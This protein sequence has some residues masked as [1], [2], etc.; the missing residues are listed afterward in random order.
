MEDRKLFANNLR[1]NSSAPGSLY[2]SYVTPA[3]GKA[4]LGLS[5][6]NIYNSTLVHIYST[7][8]VKCTDMGIAINIEHKSKAQ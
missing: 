3:V 6:A 8:L 4:D 2:L 1:Q 7:W 5:W